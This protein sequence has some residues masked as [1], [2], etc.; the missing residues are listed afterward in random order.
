MQFFSYLLIR[1]LI[2]GRRIYWGCTHPFTYFFD[3]R[4]CSSRYEKDYLQVLPKLCQA[5]LIRIFHF[6]DRWKVVSVAP[7]RGVYN[8]HTSWAVFSDKLAT[9]SRLNTLYGLE[10][11]YVQSSRSVTIIKKVLRHI[12]HF[13][14]IYKVINVQFFA[15]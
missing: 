13:W 8:P 11:W 6:S 12:W 5:P 4:L 3:F 9:A 10:T 15:I 7:Q 1:G 14:L 2:N